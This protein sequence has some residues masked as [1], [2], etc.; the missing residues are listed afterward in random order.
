L[1]VLVLTGFFAGLTALKAPH[2]D[3]FPKA[4]LNLQVGEEKKAI[5]ATV[6]FERDTLI[7]A[8]ERG[9]GLK[10]FSYAT[11]KNAVYSFAKSPR[12][13]RILGPPSFLVASAKKH[14]LIVQGGD[15]NAVLQLDRGNYKM[16]LAA[17]EAR[18]GKKIDIVED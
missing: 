3:T 1:I 18:T 11:I 4:K 2:C 13:R 5:E 6:K 15:D 17:F 10:T 12:Q 9:L 16:I 8:D 7:V 14:W